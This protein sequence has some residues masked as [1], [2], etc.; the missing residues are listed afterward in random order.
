MGSQVEDFDSWTSEANW[1]VTQGYFNKG[2]AGDNE[3]LR[4]ILEGHNH[5]DIFSIYVGLAASGNRLKVGDNRDEAGSDRS[6]WILDSSGLFISL[7]LVMP[8]VLNKLKL[9]I[10]DLILKENIYEATAEITD[11]GPC[12][13]LTLILLSLQNKECVYV[14]EVYVF[15]DPIDSGYP[16]NQVEQKENSS[17]SSLM[18]MLV[19][20]ILQLSKASIGRAQEKHACSSTEKQ[21][22]Q[23][24]KI[25]E[26]IGT[27]ETN[28]GK[29]ETENVLEVR[30]LPEDG[31]VVKSYQSEFLTGVP[32]TEN[33]TDSN[34]SVFT[35]S[36]IGRTLDQLVSR[37]GRI[38]DFCLR[39]EK[40]MLKPTR[41]QQMEQQLE[42]LTKK[43]ESFRPPSCTG[44]SGSVPFLSELES[45][46]CQDEIH[47]KNCVMLEPNKTDLASDKLSVQLPSDDVPVSVNATQLSPSLI[48]TAQKFPIQV[49]NYVEALAVKAPDFPDDED[50]KDPG[51]DSPEF[52]YQ[53]PRACLG[54]ISSP[55]SGE[56]PISSLNHDSAEPK[57]E[58]LE[59]SSQLYE[60]G[61]E[62]YIQVHDLYAQDKHDMTSLCNGQITEETDQRGS[63]SQ[64]TS[65]LDPDE[66]D[67][68]NQ[69][70]NEQISH[71]SDS[72]PDGMPATDGLVSTTEVP[73][74]SVQDSLGFL[75]LSGSSRVDFETQNH[76]PLEALLNDRK[77][78]NFEPSCVSEDDTCFRIGLNDN[79]I[80]VNVGE[81]RDASSDASLMV[82]FESSNMENQPLEI[83]R[84]RRVRMFYF[85]NV[86]VNESSVD[87]DHFLIFKYEQM[88][89]SGIEPINA[90][91]SQLSRAECLCW[92]EDCY[93]YFKRKKE[94][95][96]L[97]KQR[98]KAVCC[99]VRPQSTEVF[100]QQAS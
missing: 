81:I 2:P 32:D 11:V 14:D 63:N 71:S 95:H 84:L 24:N 67:T 8:W 65:A 45:S 28:D 100:G 17:G 1:E 87:L 33:K 3:D 22:F 52:W 62:S 55:W 25:E 12:T 83:E 26:T 94:N 75:K 46:H 23:E 56:E 40:N 72:N 41:L 27:K 10:S 60:E 92:E 99:V 97:H 79:S 31:S 73:E 89:A 80:L 88:G 69:F 30:L 61:K 98:N 6:P 4:T 44:A 9:C 74:E 68:S 39:F 70:F 58:G 13:C 7:V 50:T 77:D 90:T 59:K 66:T 47:H 57:A 37:V 86:L 15:A 42:A 34:A 76:K 18:A 20:A 64:V 93:S 21:L 38:E 78:S 43:S 49:P 36:H 82:E 53:M 85:I 5:V 91:A 29:C 19:P 35:S 16:E 54:K 96:S 48:V 51:I